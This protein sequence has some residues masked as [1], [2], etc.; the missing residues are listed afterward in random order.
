MNPLEVLLVAVDI[1]V[2]VGL[3]VPFMGRTRWLDFVPVGAIVIAI[4]HLVLEGFRPIMIPVYL[5]TGLLFGRSLWRL[6]RA[7]PTEGPR[8]P[9]LRRILLVSSSVLGV[10]LVSIP[11]IFSPLV[12]APA[13]YSRMGWSA[14]FDAMH[15]HFS[16]EYPF[17]QWK[18]IDWDAL[19]AEYVPRVAAA[20]ESHDTRAYY[21]ALRSYVY[22]VPNGH[23]RLEGDDPGLRKDAIGGGYGLNVIGLDDGRVIASQV[24]ADGPAAKAGMEWGAEI[25]GWNGQPI[26]AA[27]DHVSTVWARGSPATTEGRRIE[28][29]RFLVRAPVGDEAR[30]TFRNPGDAKARTVTLTAIDDQLEMLHRTYLNP[31]FQPSKTP[32]RSKILPSG[33]GYIKID[34]EYSTRDGYDPEAVMRQ[35]VE[36]FNTKQV[37]GVILDVRGNGGGADDWVPKIVGFFFSEPS[38][39][40]YRAYYAE[41]IDQFVVLPPLALSIQPLKPHYA[42]PVVVLVDNE[43]MSSAEGIPMAIQRLP[44]G[45]VMGFWVRRG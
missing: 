16:H 26:E 43:T 33:H 31:E 30:I 38:H 1:L 34:A 6:L 12:P 27:L 36:E 39:Y 45:Q 28:Q 4:A 7:V 19:H 21:L 13:N 11:V 8:R 23:V 3:L 5:V 17:G 14:A 25:L 22:S 2:L 18:A 9:R 35:A 10:L 42:G 24:Q 20:E 40:E 32:I 44:R 37:P 15:A 41:G 29:Y